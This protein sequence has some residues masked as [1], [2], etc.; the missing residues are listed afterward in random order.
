MKVRV[1]ALLMA[2]AVVSGC[3]QQKPLVATTQFD[4][5]EVSW[6][7]GDGTNTVTGFAV[8]R[9][10]G[11]EA[12]TCAALMVRLI[13]DSAYARERMVGIFGST[14]QGTAKVTGPRYDEAATDKAYVA[15]VRETRCDGQG[16]FSFERVPNGIWYVSA[17][18]VW[19]ANPRSGTLEGGLMMKRVDLAGGQSVKVA[20]P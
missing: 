19:S 20:L 2:V 12:R 10:V 3:V 18:V 16:N 8:L 6:S 9:T 4:P 1:A 5:N 7:K 13:P 17:A 11:G 14:T 15:S